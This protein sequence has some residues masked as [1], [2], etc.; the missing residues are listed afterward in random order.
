MLTEAYVWHGLAI[1]VGQGTCIIS[2]RFDV[3]RVRTMIT[4]PRM[5]IFYAINPERILRRRSGVVGA[6]MLCTNGFRALSGIVYM[7]RS[8]QIKLS[9]VA[10]VLLSIQQSL[11]RFHGRRRAL[12]LHISSSKI[13]KCWLLFLVPSESLSLI[14]YDGDRMRKGNSKLRV[15]GE[16]GQEKRCLFSCGKIIFLPIAVI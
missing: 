15:T 8:S 11:S 12:L 5:T 10:V 3:N 9:Y 7:I 6:H 1:F 14:F 16:S 2:R 13:W 4:S